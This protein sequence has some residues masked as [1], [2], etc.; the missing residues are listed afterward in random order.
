MFA[1]LS[2]WT[3]QLVPSPPIKDPSEI[4]EKNPSS[5]PTND[6]VVFKEPETELSGLGTGLEPKVLLASLTS[7]LPKKGLGGGMQWLR[8]LSNALPG[9][10]PRSTKKT[11]K[12][13][14][15]WDVLEDPEAREELKKNIL[16][17]SQV[18][19]IHALYSQT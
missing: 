2:A 4:V 13:V 3:S 7:H 18:N 17:L 10:S 6:T 8:G 1:S 5:L 19:S 14:H 9:S 16:D 11:G 15:P 12:V